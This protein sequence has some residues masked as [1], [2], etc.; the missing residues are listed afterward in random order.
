MSSGE[1]KKK[2]WKNKWIWDYENNYSR[3]KSIIISRWYHDGSDFQTVYSLRTNV[4]AYKYINLAFEMK[5]SERSAVSIN[6]SM[7]I[8]YISHMKVIYK[9]TLKKNS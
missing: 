9:F 5:Y 2:L 1:K 4:N 3:L 6:K 8:E 7:Q